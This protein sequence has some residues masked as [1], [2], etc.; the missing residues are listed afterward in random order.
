MVLLHVI[1]LLRRGISSGSTVFISL[2]LGRRS[3]ETEGNMTSL[4]HIVK[5]RLAE[6]PE[7]PS[8]TRRVTKS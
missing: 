8:F 2:E 3:Q 4:V 5:P 6:L 7:T 1:R